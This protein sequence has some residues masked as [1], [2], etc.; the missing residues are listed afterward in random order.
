L[1]LAD[2]RNRIGLFLD[3]YNF[4]RPHQGIDGLVPADRFFGAAPEVLKT[5]KARVAANALELA[6]HG[7][8]KD[9]FYLTGQVDGQPFSVHRQGDRVVLQRG[10]RPSE[11][12]ELTDME[13]VGESAVA[14]ELPSSN[15]LPQAVCPDGSPGVRPGEPASG[16]ALAPG[17]SVLDDVNIMDNRSELTAP[18][19]DVSPVPEGSAP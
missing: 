12:I 9:P 4:L 2:A 16:P 14:G 7:I 1:D 8:P 15:T 10:D 3:Y 6:C 11:E 17:E 5:L 18:T 19:D 13:S